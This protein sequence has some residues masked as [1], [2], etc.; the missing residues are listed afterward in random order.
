MYIAWCFVSFNK[1]SLQNTLILGTCLYLP[2]ISVSLTPNIPLLNSFFLIHPLLLYLIVGYLLCVYMNGLVY[3]KFMIYFL[4]LSLSI[5]GIWSLQEFNW[6]GWWNWDLLELFILLNILY[7]TF[8]TH[9]LVQYTNFFKNSIIFF[10]IL[11]FLAIYFLFNKWG[12][13]ISIH[14]FSKSIFFKNYFYYYLIIILIIGQLYLY[15]NYLLS[16][17]FGIYLYIYLNISNLSVIKFI[18]VYMYMFYISIQFRN[19]FLR[20]LHNIGKII[21]LSVVIF[22]FFN[23]VFYTLICKTNY[24]SG[25]FI[26]MI[27]SKLLVI[28]FSN[29][30]ALKL[31]GKFFF[32]KLNSMLVSNYLI[33]N[34]TNNIMNY[35]YSYYY[36]IPINFFIFFFIRK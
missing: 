26:D 34:I 2:L 12:L 33:I 1:T 4:Y 20:I 9:K 7:I 6:G 27:F 22:N 13:S 24:V 16:V 8:K 14:S 17:Y 35:T 11:L 21:I 25:L 23:N 18:F 30:I 32:F 3:N 10:K 5:G 19:N 28:D 31:Y 15:K 29:V 36:Y